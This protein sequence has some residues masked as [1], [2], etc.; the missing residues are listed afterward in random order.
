MLPKGNHGNIGIYLAS[1]LCIIDA[2]H[3]DNAPAR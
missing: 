2:L 1:I 3:Q